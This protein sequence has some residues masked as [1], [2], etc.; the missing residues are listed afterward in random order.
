MRRQGVN[1]AHERLD[2]RLPRLAQALLALWRE[3]VQRAEE[4]R[5]AVDDG[6]VARRLGD[7]RDGKV[8]QARGE[9]TERGREEREER[10]DGGD[11]GE[12]DLLEEGPG[13]SSTHMAF[14]G[15][16]SVRR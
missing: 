14:E 15:S 13:V 7:E 3:E 8:V 5:A 6:G 1:A 9:R 12:L 16:G 11:A 2:T 4:G 10:D